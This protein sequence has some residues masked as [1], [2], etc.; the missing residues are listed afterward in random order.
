MQKC[1]LKNQRMKVMLLHHLKHPLNYYFHH[2]III[3]THDVLL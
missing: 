1:A 2:V 3:D